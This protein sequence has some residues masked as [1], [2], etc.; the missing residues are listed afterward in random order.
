MELV[1][2]CPQC[3]HVSSTGIEADFDTITRAQHRPIIVRCK[4][5]GR[6]DLVSVANALATT[7]FGADGTFASLGPR[8]I[9]DWD[10]E[11]RWMQLT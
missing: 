4:I 5:C 8:G 11:P 3:L 10:G 2:C 7:S 1:F 6:L 9:N